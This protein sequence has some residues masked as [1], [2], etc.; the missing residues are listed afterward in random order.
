MQLMNF[1][2]IM[3]ITNNFS[4]H[5]HITSKYNIM[6]ETDSVKNAQNDKIENVAGSV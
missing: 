1:F 4:L 2:S 6:E 3:I 5:S